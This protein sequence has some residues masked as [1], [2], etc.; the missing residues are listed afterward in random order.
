MAKSN[1]AQS[2][3]LLFGWY[4]LSSYMFPIPGLESRERQA[5]YITRESQY[6][7]LVYPSWQAGQHW[8]AGPSLWYVLVARNAKG[9][10]LSALDYESNLLDE[11][12][13]RP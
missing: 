7:L 8:L 1:L 11:S 3:E 13:Y 5:V 9:S 2:I 10:K 4:N 6:I 12:F